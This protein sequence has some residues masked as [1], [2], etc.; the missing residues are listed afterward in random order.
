MKQGIVTAGHPQTAHAAAEILKAGGNAFDAAIAALFTVCVTEPALASLGGGG[1]LMANPQAGKPILFDFFVHTPGVRK[2]STEVRSEVFICDFGDT[3]QEFI[4]GPGTSAVPG[5]V[6][7]IFEVARRFSKMP[8]KELIEPALEILKEGVV[9][10]EMQAHV[11]KILTPIYLSG[12]AGAI[13]ASKIK[14]GHTVQCGETTFFP[15]LEDLLA[16]LAVEGDALFYRGEIAKAIHELSSDGGQITYDDMQNYEVELREPLQV[17]YR[18]HRLLLNPPPASGGI[19]IGLAMS[20]LASCH[21]ARHQFGSTEHL[22]AIMD[23]LV[24]CARLEQN[25]TP[26]SKVGFDPRLVEIYRAHQEWLA[27]NGTTHISIIDRDGNAVAVSVSNGEGCGTMIPGTSVMLN[28]MLGEHDVN[29]YGLTE[30]PLARR[31]S[32]LMSPTVVTHESGMQIAIGSGGSNRIPVI[33]QQV[34]INLLDFEM[35]VKEAVQA[36]RVH[37][38]QQ[39]A[40]AENLFG[41][42]ALPEI[43]Q[44]YGNATL[45]KKNDVFFGGVHTA[46]QSG[47][48]VEGFGDTRRGGVWVVVS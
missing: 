39:A 24:Q 43:L 4:I 36:P 20:R 34:L 15:Q 42:Q 12:K 8:M 44:R 9:I 14:P 2:A 48:R 37:Y 45:F 3:Q 16:T 35:S 30:W 18:E 29:P 41:N 19:A 40:Y 13:F 38:H 26:D 25:F 31:L 28:N 33:I 22:L 21:L 47:D 32:S 17:W 7:G 11:L 1:F 23:T 10:N 6:K 46:R 27:P 5:Y